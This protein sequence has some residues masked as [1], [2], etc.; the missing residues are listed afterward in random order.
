MMSRQNLLKQ[1]KRNSRDNLENPQR[2]L[3][4]RIVSRDS[5]GLQ[6]ILFVY[7]FMISCRSFKNGRHVTCQINSNVPGIQ[8]VLHKRGNTGHLPYSS[9]A[10]APWF[11]RIIGGHNFRINLIA[12]SLETSDFLYEKGTCCICSSSRY[13]FLTKKVANLFL[14]EHLGGVPSLWLFESPELYWLFYRFFEN[15]ELLSQ[16]LNKKF[17]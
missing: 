2:D 1:F 10:A 5:R 7:L 4:K 3:S 15:E 16:P 14:T 13:F 12:I 17:I 6:I 8:T 9:Y 11:L